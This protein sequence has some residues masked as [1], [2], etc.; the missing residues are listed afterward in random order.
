[1]VEK[2]NRTTKRSYLKETLKGP[3]FMRG[4]FYITSISLQFSL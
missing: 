1:M 2:C 3:H 4:P